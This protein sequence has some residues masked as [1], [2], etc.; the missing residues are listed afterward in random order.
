VTGARATRLEE[1]Q[2]ATGPELSRVV[3]SRFA[4]CVIG[5]GVL[6]S[7]GKIEACK[8]N[9]FWK[10]SSRVGWPMLATG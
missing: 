8:L 9:Q 7:E 1:D 5:P 4:P 6:G 2:S 3:D 10:S